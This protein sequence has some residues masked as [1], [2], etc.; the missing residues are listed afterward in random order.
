MFSLGCMLAGQL[1]ADRRGMIWGFTL[2]LGINSWLYL[3]AHKRLE[4]LFPLVFLEGQDSWG[5]LPLLEKLS[6]RVGV[7]APRLALTPLRAPLAWSLGR[8]HK[9]ATVVISEGAL[10]ELPKEQ[11]AALLVHELIRIQRHDTL[12]VG[13]ATAWAAA[14]SWP[15]RRANASLTHRRGATFIS[16][17]V[18][19]IE[20]LSQFFGLV[21]ERISL[22]PRDVLAA[23]GATGEALGN[24]AL[25]AQ[26]LDSLEA[27]A[28]RR[29]VP[30][31]PTD[32]PIFCSSP[33]V[34]RRWAR[35]LLP[36]PSAETRI[37]RLTGRNPF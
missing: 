19:V 29:P 20:T 9:G 22:S 30:T 3:R 36:Q 35:W 7:P 1:I 14:V 15:A 34:P 21:W 13:M 28:Q 33:N 23:D 26:T 24:P 25:W 10:R 2:A 37:R 6:Q 31:L 8:G 5:L 4:G 32:V 17:V 18:R 27:F 11:V 12:A 16:P